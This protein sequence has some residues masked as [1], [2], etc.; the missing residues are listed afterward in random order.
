MCSIHLSGPGLIH[1]E[2]CEY[3]L[4]QFH[5]FS[6]KFHFTSTIANQNYTVLMYLRVLKYLPHYGAAVN[7]DMQVFLQEDTETVGYMLNTDVAAS[8]D[9]SF[10]LRNLTQRN[11]VAELFYSISS[12]T[13]SPF[14]M[15]S[16]PFVI[17]DE[18]HYTWGEIESKNNFKLHFY[19]SQ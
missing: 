9:H 14:S 12:N 13:C 3:I 4:F 7:R 5:S 8:N 15:S 2:Y 17:S 18:G 11:T 6:C 19:D 16:P 1:Y 10:F